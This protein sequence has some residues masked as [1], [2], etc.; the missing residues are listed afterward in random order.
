MKKYTHYGIQDFL[1]EES[2]VRWVLHPDPNNE[3]FWE[4][5]ISQHPDMV[6]KVKTAR[7]IILGIRYQEEYELPEKD[8]QQMLEMLKKHQRSHYL[9]AKSKGNERWIGRLV[10]SILLFAGGLFAWYE[11]SKPAT[12][13][14]PAPLVVKHT[15]KGEKLTFKLPDGTMVTLN[16]NSMLIYQW[17]QPTPDNREVKLQGEAFF[18]VA[19]DT[20]RP[21]VIT[22]GEVQ[23][24]VLGTQFNVRAYED[25]PGIQVAVVSGKVQVAGKETGAITLLPQ[26]VGL[27]KKK[28]HV[29]EATEEP[30]EDIIAWQ[31]NILI[32]DQDAAGEVW[33]KLEDWYGVNI[34]IRNK[35]NIKGRYSGKFHNQSLEEVL[36]GISFASGFDYEIVDKKNVIIK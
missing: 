32:F 23:T 31:H 15:K 16:A 1:K 9:Y 36:D 11:M 27:Y 20:A 14:P 28:E 24:T 26:E 13:I 12:L 25:E 29:L 30:V 10:A 35:Q 33:K 18:E 34:I 7:E 5:F 22:S 21:F 3:K 19:K 8:K 17:S 4:D 2:F 6:R